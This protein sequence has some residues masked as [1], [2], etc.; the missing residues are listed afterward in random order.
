MGFRYVLSLQYQS[1]DPSYLLT[2]LSALK[3]RAKYIYDDDVIRY[4]SIENFKYP[5]FELEEVSLS[6]INLLVHT[7]VGLGSLN[8]E[9]KYRLISQIE[10]SLYKY[11]PQLNHPSLKKEFEYLHYWEES[12][13]SQSILSYIMR[14]DEANWPKALLLDFLD[15]SESMDILHSTIELYQQAIGGDS[16]ASLSTDTSPD[17]G[18]LGSLDSK[19]CEKIPSSPPYILLVG[20]AFT[21]SNFDGCITSAKY[22]CDLLGHLIR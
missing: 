20:D 12:Q 4:L 18:R 1:A 17:P 2:W 13:S 3:W 7:K 9:A 19:E 5:Q 22:A 15:A 11:L 10:L 21:Q 6:V 14:E 8:E 16:V